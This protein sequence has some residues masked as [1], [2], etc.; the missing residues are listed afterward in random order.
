M[1]PGLAGCEEGADARKAQGELMKVGW[2]KH[3][4]NVGG[5]APELRWAIVR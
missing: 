5:V 2:R 1:V 3:D 4:G